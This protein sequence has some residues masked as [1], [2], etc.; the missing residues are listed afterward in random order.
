MHA[1]YIRQNTALDRRAQRVGVTEITLIGL[2]CGLRPVS[3]GMRR[4]P[5]HVDPH[6]TS[7]H[8]A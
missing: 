8:S 4:I 6:H 1:L 5:V 2:I 7:H 3:E